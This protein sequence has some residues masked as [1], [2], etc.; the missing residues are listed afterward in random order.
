MTNKG[1]IWKKNKTKHVYAKKDALKI[2][3]IYYMVV[4]DIL[5]LI[6]D[7]EYSVKLL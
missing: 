6:I 4:F 2:T 1:D 7:F 3:D 5:K